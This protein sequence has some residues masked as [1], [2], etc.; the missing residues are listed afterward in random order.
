[1]GELQFYNNF[2]MSQI[3]HI[4]FITY[5]YTKM[6]RNWQGYTIQSHSF[7]S[8]KGNFVVR[9]IKID[10][11]EKLSEERRIKSNLISIN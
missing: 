3:K 8:V 10:N 11:W 9:S 2:D 4:Y 6:I 7:C 1:M 5:P